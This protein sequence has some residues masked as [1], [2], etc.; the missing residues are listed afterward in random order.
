MSK[1]FLP[2]RLN[3]V[4]H[5]LLSREVLLPGEDRDLLNAF[6]TRCLDE[7]QPEGEMETLL[8]DRIVSSAWRLKRAVKIEKQGVQISPLDAPD[9]DN[10]I[11]GGDYRYPSW[12]VF[13]RYETALENQVFRALH[14]L[15]R[16]QFKRRSLENPPQMPGVLP[17]ILE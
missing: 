1:R 14:E 16:L 3:A 4:S 2:A 8:V 5:G 7:F 10:C 6:R 15:E 13:M 11:V 12:L 9:T 17:D